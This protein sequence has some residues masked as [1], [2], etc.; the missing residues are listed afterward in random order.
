MILQER[1]NLKLTCA[2]S[3]DPKPVENIFTFFKI[4]FFCFGIVS[5]E[6][7]WLPWFS[8]VLKLCHLTLKVVAWSRKDGQTI[9]DGKHL[10]TS[11]V[12]NP[13]LNITHIN[14]YKQILDLVGL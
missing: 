14:R 8:F 4:G 2:A 3:G 10:R 5:F 1:E 9:I 11:F 6:S 12:P 13:V 7:R